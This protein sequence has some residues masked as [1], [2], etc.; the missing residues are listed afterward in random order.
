M[1]KVTRWTRTWGLTFLS[2]VAVSLQLSAQQFTTLVN[3]NLSNGA[4]PQ[5]AF[6]EGK[7]GNLYGTTTGGG[8]QVCCGTIFKISTSGDFKTIYNFQ[9]GSGD[10]PTSLFLAPNGTYF[11]TTIIGGEADWGTVFRSYKKGIVTVHS[12]TCDQNC[13]GGIVPEAGVVQ[14]VDGMF[15]GTTA[16]GGKNKNGTVFKVASDGRFKTLYKF[17]GPDGSEPYAGLTLGIDGDLY[18]TTEFG[19]ENCIGCGNIFKITTDGNL[20]VIHDFNGVDGESSFQLVQG[21]NGILYGT[22]PGG[23]FN[24]QG[25]VFSITPDGTFTTLYTFCAQPGCSDGSGP[26]AALMQASDGNFYG[27]TG[28]GG[29]LTCRPPDGCGVLFRISASGNFDI[30]HNFES[31]EGRI[32]NQLFQHTNGKLYGATFF[33]GSQD[34]GTVFSL[35]LG[36]SPFVAFLRAY[37]KIGETG[38][39]VGQGFT[40]TTAVTINGVS[41]TFKVVSDTYLTAIVPQ[42]ATTGYVTV[43]TPNESL[44]SNVPFRVIP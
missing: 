33:G 30:V 36:F 27:V 23:G 13:E 25:T 8:A 15:Y 5:M 18:G 35:D 43:I 10:G 32:P 6:I 37:G 16:G 24:D 20:T 42:G 21:T 3:F 22:T 9:S 19:G 41:A 4:N 28:Y 2:F 34:D 38:G 29:D 40:G 7:D 14:G 31:T 11:G 1:N 26:S 17:S 39:I 12:F 44:T